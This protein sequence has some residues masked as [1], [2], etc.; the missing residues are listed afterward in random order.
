MSLKT[1][2]EFEQIDADNP[3]SRESTVEIS[4]DGVPLARR[5]SSSL[6]WYPNNI[7]QLGIINPANEDVQK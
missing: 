7:V 4:L 5:M 1:S 3:R 2:E 6:R